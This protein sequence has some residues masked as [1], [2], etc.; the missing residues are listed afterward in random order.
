LPIN[1]RNDILREE[2]KEDT[3]TDAGNISHLAQIA[4]EYAKRAREAKKSEW[5]N[6]FYKGG[7]NMAMHAA[8]CIKGYETKAKDINESRRRAVA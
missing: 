8:R 5:L 7:A 2:E 3:M 6:G 1:W 4:R